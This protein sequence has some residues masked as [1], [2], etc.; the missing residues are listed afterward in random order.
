MPFP[1]ED[2][3]VTLVDYREEWE[4]EYVVIATTI[5]ALG[6][7]EHGAVEHVGSTAIPGMTAKDVI[8]VQVRLPFLDEEAV[9]GRFREIGFRRRPE[10]W[11]NLERTRDGVIPKLVFAP[12]QGAR[13]Q[14][15]HVRV[16]GTAGARDTLLFRDYLRAS[17]E[18]VRA[19]S[20][21]KRS[22]VRGSNPLNLASYGQAKQPAWLELM[23]RAD[24]WA[25]TSSW[26]ESPLTAWNA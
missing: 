2:V 6:L 21:F 4:H 11:N 14:N 26:H 3:P 10:E 17:A 23:N 13:P 12:R 5:R 7:S 24:E 15:V 25:A 1:D 8:D 22:I 16:D 18:A 20:D 19:W 9:T